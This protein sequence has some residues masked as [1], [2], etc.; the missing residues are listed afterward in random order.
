MKYVNGATRLSYIW[1]SFGAI[2]I[3]SCRVA[4]GD[5][6]RNLIISQLPGGKATINVVAA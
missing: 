4:I 1:N 5:H 2:E 3:I 6:E